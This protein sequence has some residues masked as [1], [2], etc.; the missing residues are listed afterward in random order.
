MKM[1]LNHLALAAIP[2]LA[3]SGSA[4]PAHAGFHLIQSAV[5]GG[6][7]GW[8]D[9]TVDPA[10]RRLYLSRGSHVMVLDADSLRVVGDIPHTPGVHG[11]ALAPGLGRGY[12][13]N[14]GDTTVTVFDLVTLKE[15]ARV[16]VGIRPD[17]ILF[18]PATTRVFTFNASSKD[19]TAIDAERNEVVGTVP[20]EGKPEFA[21]TDGK[22]HMFVN[23]EDKNEVI[24]FDTRS[25][26]VVA[27]WGLVMGEGPTGLAFDDSSGILFAACG[28]EK[29]IMLDS[30]TGML[31]GSIPIGKGPDGAGWDAGRG[32]A[33]SSNGEGSLTVIERQKNG[34]FKVAET[35]PT[36]PGARTM[37]LDPKTHRVYLVTSQFG[38]APAP[39]ADKPHPR[40]PILPGTFEVLVYGE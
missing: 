26:K 38:E 7:G 34:S 33:F 15:L 16:R 2:L 4:D 36:K 6:E 14:G 8:D 27:H 30:E 20:L 13:S 23:I 24:E 3:L 5:I 40:A 9:L 1:S 31:R 28:N 39:T 22:G 37:T 10:A 12:T 29:M 18:D 11:I 17:A 19:A 32:R 21:R 35:V 25:L